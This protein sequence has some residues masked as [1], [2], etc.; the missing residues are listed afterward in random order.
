ME[1]EKIKVG[2]GEC[3]ESNS[4]LVI[5]RY[6]EIRHNTTTTKPRTFPLN[7]IMGALKF[8]SL[9]YSCDTVF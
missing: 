6:S 8:F 7:G 1:K 4:S 5:A 3:E 9:E 2:E